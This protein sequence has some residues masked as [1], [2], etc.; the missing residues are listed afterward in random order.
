MKY[1]LRPEYIG[2]AF[3]VIKERHNARK[4]TLFAMSGKSRYLAHWANVLTGDE[5]VIYLVKDEDLGL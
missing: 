5:I 2:I 4:A 3:D 1:K